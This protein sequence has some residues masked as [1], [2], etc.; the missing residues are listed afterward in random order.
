[1]STTATVD[2]K[3]LPRL[4]RAMAVIERVGNALPHP[5]WPW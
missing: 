4:V 2:R 1:M 3:E 5:C